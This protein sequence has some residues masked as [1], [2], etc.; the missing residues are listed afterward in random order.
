MYY[1]ARISENIEADIERNWSAWQTPNLG[2]SYEDCEQD[3]KDGFAVGEIREFPEFPGSFGIIHHYGLS[4]YELTA[5]SLEDAIIE[6]NESNVFDGSG[7]GIAAYNCKL[8]KS[9]GN[10]HIL[11]CENIESE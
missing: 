6:V 1:V 8:A 5:S 11:L 9:I 10:V 4:C 7:F 2:G 3:I